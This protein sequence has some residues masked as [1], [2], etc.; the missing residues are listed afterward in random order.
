MAKI[1]VTEYGDAIARQANAGLDKNI[2]FGI[3]QHVICNGFVD[4]HQI[5]N[6]HQAFSCRRCNFYL[7]F[8]IAI[9]TWRLLMNFSRAV[10][11][12]AKA[13]ERTLKG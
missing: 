10:S 13:A 12:V 9:T 5:S 6:T 8:P 7:R 1:V 2:D 3:K 4:L 11:C